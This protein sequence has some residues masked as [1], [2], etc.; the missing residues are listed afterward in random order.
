[1]SKVLLEKQLVYLDFRQNDYKFYDVEVLSVGYNDVQV[2]IRSGVLGN[3]GRQT[4]ERFSDKKTSS[5]KDATVLKEAMKFA[6]T[7]I[8]ERKSKGYIS[9]EKMEEGLKYAI[10][11]DSQMEKQKKIKSSSQ[12]EKILECDS[13]K[14]PIDKNLY[15]KIYN[16]AR[17]TSKGNWDSDPTRETYK[18]VF[19]LD[20]QIEKEIFQKHF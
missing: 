7:K 11:L 18:K 10:K 20:C 2:I 12:P 9:R 16:W 4:I 1:M 3:K 5:N 19:C 14:K 15:D 6:Y 13:C 17:D 8:Y